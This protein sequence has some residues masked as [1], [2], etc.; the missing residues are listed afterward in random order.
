MCTPM[1]LTVVGGLFSA[2]SSYMGV[3]AQQQQMRYQAEA[4][5]RQYEQ[6]ALVAEQNRRLAEMQQSAA[7]AE[8]AHEEQLF[9]R[10]ARQFQAGQEAVLAA[11]GAMLSGSPLA[12]LADT[13]MGIEQDVNQIRLNALK[14]MWGY[15]VQGQ[16]LGF[17]ASEARR[18]AQYSRASV[19]R[20]SPWGAAIGSLLGTGAQIWGASHSTYNRSG[21]ITIKNP[22]NFGT[23][24]TARYVPP[25]SISGQGAWGRR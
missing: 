18:G 12:V 24:G 5:A 23:G 21:G 10:R 9:L 20:L 2:A 4:Q 16:Q 25:D 7:L 17:E 14:G 13:A 3:Q 15:Q 1:T 22:G 19:P 8:G 11:S 6:Q